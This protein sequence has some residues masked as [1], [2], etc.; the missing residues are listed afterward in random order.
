MEENNSELWAVEIINKKKERAFLIIKKDGLLTS[1][2]L[3]ADVTFFNSTKDAWFAIRKYKLD[4]EKGVICRAVKINRADIKDRK[5]ITGDIFFV[6]AFDKKRVKWWAH[7]DAEKKGF[8]FKREDLNACVFDSE[9]KANGII[10]G[11]KK[12]FPELMEEYVAE[13]VVKSD[14]T[15]AIIF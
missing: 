13:K 5:H 9:E 6:T 7:W 4:R 15:Q 8:I 3:I 14:L 2:Q 12:T 11:Y 10:E 1:Q